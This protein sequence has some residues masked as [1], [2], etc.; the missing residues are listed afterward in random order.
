MAR[1]IWWQ[2]MDRSVPDC[3]YTRREVTRLLKRARAT[4][5]EV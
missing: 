3:K 1:V 4:W 5:E 2:I